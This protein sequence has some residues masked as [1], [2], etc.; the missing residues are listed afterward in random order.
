MDDAQLFRQIRD[1]LF[2]AAVG[3]V[4]DTMGFQHQFLPAGIAPLE[5]SMRIVGR[6]MPVL[7]ADVV[8]DG[9]RSAGPLS[10]KP[11]GLMLE[12]LDDL[13]PG[14]IY[15]ATGASLRYALWGGLM[16][17]R[18]QHLKAAGAI[19][20]GYVR[21]AGEIERL[22]FDVFCRGTYAQDQGVR[23]QVIDYRCTIEIEGV[24]IA[25]GDLLFGDREGVLVIPR[26][27]EREAVAKALDKVRTENKVADAIRGGMSACEALATFG[28]M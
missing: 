18:A 27:V 24:R 1:E 28:V 13:K 9:T 16:S 25:P 22:G 8:N 17:T 5:K 19:L 6:A 2:V 7:E 14:E 21:D 26:A 15:I 10:G 12:A 20:D 11:F 3:D 4:L 23:G